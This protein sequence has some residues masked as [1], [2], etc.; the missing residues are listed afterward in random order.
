MTDVT[1]INASFPRGKPF[2]PRGTLILASVLEQAGYKIEVKDYQLADE[3]NAASPEQFA[4]FLS[5]SQSKTLGISTLSNTLPTVILG[6]R[7]FKQRNPESTI[8]MGGA[9]VAE[10]SELIFSLAP[11]DVIVIGEGEITG[12]EVFNRIL[13]GNPIGDLQGVV[14][15]Q[16]TGII[17]NKKQPIINELDRFPLPNYDHIDFKNY[18]NEVTILT[19]RGCPYHCAFCAKPIWKN[20]VTYSP[21]AR[22]EKEIR[23]VHHR[24]DFINFA[25]DCFV[26]NANRVKKLTSKLRKMDFNTPWACT[27]KIEL[28]S[29]K[30]LR[31]L[32][33]AGCVR[34]ELG[35]ESGNKRVLRSLGKDFTPIEARSKITLAMEYI[36]SIYTSYIWGLP[37]ETL[38]DFYDTMFFVMEDFNRRK[39]RPFL[40]LLTP[41][42][43][44]ILLKEYRHKLNFLENNRYNGVSFLNGEYLSK[45]PELKRF[46]LKHPD[47]FPMFYYFDQP[48]FEKKRKFV[49]QLISQSRIGKYKEANNETKGHNNY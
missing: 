39:I 12:L 19:A 23:A 7:I 36:D 33:E 20:A 9:G 42:P 48:G 28:I 8:V 6:I 13:N 49:D 34:L 26:S 5:N 43:S 31:M 11:I 24:V 40:T 45:Y 10:N 38:D 44:T 47:V 46:V 17:S 4:Q 37:F 41:Y 16:E 1:L 3:K 22:V 32:S 35:I 30:T 21:L 29:D 15:C 2:V 18:G 27:G 25:D 14:Y